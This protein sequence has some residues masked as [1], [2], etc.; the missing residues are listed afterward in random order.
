MQDP[1]IMTGR[2]PNRAGPEIVVVG[3]GP[4]GS[5]VATHLAR[6]GRRVLL[7]EK[8]KTARPRVCGEYL[9][10]ECL[11]LVERLGALNSLGE[12]RPYRL[13]GMRIHTQS[14]SVLL[15]EFPA[16]PTDLSASNEPG[17]GLGSWRGGLAISRPV[18]DSVLLRNAC[19]SGVEILRGVTVTDLLQDS[20]RVTGVR[21]WSPEGFWDLRCRLVIGADGRHS[22]IARALG[23]RKA[24]PRLRK[25]GF[26]L[27]YQG[28]ADPGPY[29]EVFLAGDS[30]CILNPMGNGRLTLGL[31]IPAADVSS[32]PGS[33]ETLIARRLETFPLV[34][35]RLGAAKPLPEIRGI[36]PLAFRTTRQVHH[37]ALLVGDAAGFFDPLTGEGIHIALRGAELAAE[38]AHEA[39]AAGDTSMATLV[40]YERLRRQVLLPKNR[41]CAV[42]QAVIRR[43]LLA[44]FLAGRLMRRT[45]LREAFMGVI[46]DSLPTTTLLRTLCVPGPSK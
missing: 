44:D 41:F 37:G 5:A 40:R 8:A 23:L 3:G 2:Q 27:R 11:R 4:A 35:D 12:E 33:P 7:I 6:L 46:G 19:R 16:L 28:V 10:P 43:P 13:R 15:G 26:I 32:W 34:G 45:D 39:L 21:I 22:T 29:G 24:H 38:V 1:G 18:F 17:A 42:L 36:S 25:T 30:Y 14:G 9:S 31:V 20:D